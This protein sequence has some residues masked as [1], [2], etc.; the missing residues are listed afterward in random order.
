MHVLQLDAYSSRVGE[1]DELSLAENTYYTCTGRM[2]LQVPSV[3]IIMTVLTSIKNN[4]N[5]NKQEHYFITYYHSI[6]YSTSLF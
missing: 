1:E 2:V 4:N 6:Q 3:A 5:N